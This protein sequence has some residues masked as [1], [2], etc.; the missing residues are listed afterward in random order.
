MQL[1]SN[2]LFLA[3][4]YYFYCKQRSKYINFRYFREQS[5]ANILIINED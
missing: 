1:L 3:Y 2:G 4:Q 5:K